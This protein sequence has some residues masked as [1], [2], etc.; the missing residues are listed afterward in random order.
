LLVALAAFCTGST[1][2]VHAQ[3]RLIGTLRDQRV[4]EGCSW[5]A[6]SEGVGPG[7]ILLAE[8]D[9]SLVVMN[10]DGSD[11][12]LTLGD[13]SGRGYPS[14]VGDRVTKV[15][16]APGIRVEAAYTATWT[17]P[18]AAE[19]CEVTRFDVTFV[20]KRGDRTETVPATAEVGC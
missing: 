5:T 3:E 11:V 1:G 10:I 15:Y 17:C 14:R 2:E 9:E 8:R 6:S 7:F 12:R 13:G 20:V 18:P 4:V 19:G 16:T